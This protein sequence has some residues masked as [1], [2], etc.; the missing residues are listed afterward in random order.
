MPRFFLQLNVTT[1][2][3]VVVVTNLTYN[4]DK[5]FVVFVSEN[6][7]QSV[8]KIEII[9]RCIRESQNFR[10]HSVPTIKR[11]DEDIQRHF[12]CGTPG[13]EGVQQIV[14]DHQLCK[15]TLQCLVLLG[16]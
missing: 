11:V 3:V 14:R 7:R 10:P 2:E 1:N 9:V 5:T 15:W 13:W 4:N 12:V 16:G 8:S 6:S